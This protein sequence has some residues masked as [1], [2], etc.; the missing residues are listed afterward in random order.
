MRVPR[1]FRLAA[2]AGVFTA[3][4]PASAAWDNVFQVTCNDCRPRRAAAYYAPPPAVSYYAPAPTAPACD[5][6]APQQRSSYKVDYQQRSYYEPI[7]VMKPEKYLEPVEVRSKSYYWDPVTSYSYSSYYDPC[8]QQCQQIATPRTSYR[9]KEQCNTSYRYVERIRMVPTQSQ[10]LVTENTPV[11]TYTGP[12]TRTYSS[13]VDNCPVPPAG[14]GPTIDRMP[15]APPTV[16]PSTGNIAPP[17]LPTTENMSNPSR[18]MPPSA[19]PMNAHTTSGGAGAVRGEVV[20]NDRMTPRPNAR[21]VFVNAADY[22]KREY[23]TA[24]G[25]GNFDA[26]LPAGEWYLYVGT[27]SGKAVQH[28]EEP[29]RVGEAEAREF[30]LVSR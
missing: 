26:R 25:F 9:L 16:T 2:L 1:L 24:D 3:P 17:N 6:C 27:G 4:A 30:R 15:S 19:K 14:S 11:V 28:S 29:I 10:R 8:S 12:T 22:S 20:L 18:S 13:P 21:L 7:T 23:V 5:N